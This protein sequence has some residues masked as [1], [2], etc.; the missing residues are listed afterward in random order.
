MRISNIVC[1]AIKSVIWRERAALYRKYLWH[2]GS[3]SR[4]PRF[5]YYKTRSRVLTLTSW[6]SASKGATVVIRYIEWQ[7]QKIL[8]IFFLFLFQSIDRK[9]GLPRE[10]AGAPLGDHPRRNG[11]GEEDP[12]GARHL[13]REVAAATHQRRSPFF[14]AAVPP[15]PARSIE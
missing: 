15:P 6:N 3:R 7:Y 9:V 5:E 2:I 1:K 8:S 4:G 13:E 12:P 14:V 10:H 11:T